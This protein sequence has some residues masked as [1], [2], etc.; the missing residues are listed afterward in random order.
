ME[1][2]AKNRPRFMGAVTRAIGQ[3]LQKHNQEQVARRKSE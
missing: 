2:A 1:W 3:E